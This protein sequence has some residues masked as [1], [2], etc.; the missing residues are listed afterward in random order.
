MKKKFFFALF[1][2]VVQCSF[3]QNSI[4]QLK[5]KATQS[6]VDTAKISLYISIAIEYFKINLD[7]SVAYSKKAVSLS[8]NI[9]NKEYLFKS[10]DILGYSLLKKG[11]IKKAMPFLMK[12]YN[13]G[14]TVAISDQYFYNLFH[15]LTCY[16]QSKNSDSAFYYLNIAYTKSLTYANKGIECTCLTNYGECHRSFS[17]YDKSIE[18]FYKAINCNE[19]N[20]NDDKELK[21]TA[22]LGLGNIYFT[23]R[24]YLKAIDHYNIALNSQYAT[25][26]AGVTDLSVLYNNLGA[27]YYTEGG[28]K[29]DTTLKNKGIFFFKKVLEQNLKSGN[30]ISTG[31]LYGNLGSVYANEGRYEIA[32][33]YFLKALE[34]AVELNNKLSE[35]KNYNNLGEL[36]SML[37]DSI[38]AVECFDKALIISKKSKMKEM[39][40]LIYENVDEFY[41]AKGNFK[42]AYDAQKQYIL[43]KDSLLNEQN[44]SK[45]ETLKAQYETEKKD[46][47]ITLLA[48]DKLLKELFIDKQEGE[49]L[50]QQTEAEQ[51]VYKIKILND[52]KRFNQVLLAN[53]KI[54]KEKQHRE[55]ELLTKQNNLSKETIRQQKIITFLIAIGLLVTLIAIVLVFKQYKQKQKANEIITQQ[56][57]AAEKQKEIIEEKQKEI[58]DSIQYAK[59]I[60][61]SLLP[62]EKYIEKVLAIL[63]K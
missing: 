33:E 2:I 46:Q 62:P 6:S 39:Q 36:Y 24:K 53:E 41:S 49:L 43:T 28:N 7:S 47:Q 14:K 61:Q 16:I 15:L 21:F 63:N 19:Q 34:I 50:K 58:L 32:K 42:L 31:R 23:S 20:N 4:E 52:E 27:A 3:A 38:K 17:E 55:N 60:Q 11:E 57:E 48:K 25:E 8:E 26:S 30:K 59:R 56:K 12:A 40:I 18:Y 10:N 45:L 9:K 54:E 29:N 13:L 51:Q 1:S 37:N 35:A 5:I 22:N 44:Q